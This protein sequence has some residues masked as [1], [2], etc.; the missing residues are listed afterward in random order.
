MEPSTEAGAAATAVTAGR[1][2]SWPP[3]GYID[4][5]GAAKRLGVNPRTLREWVTDGTLAY[6]G[7]MAVAPDGRR[8]R[9]YEVAALDEARARMRAAVAGRATLP[10]G[11]VSRDDA[12]AMLGVVPDTLALWHTNGRL[13]CGTWVKTAD[14]KRRKVYPAVE[15]ERLRAALATAIVSRVTPP[16]GFVDIDGALAMFGVTRAAWNIWKRQGKVPRGTKWRSATATYCRIYA[17]EE[18]R[19]VFDRLR[20]PDQVFR[21]PGGTGRYHIPEGF[22]QLREACAMFGVEDKTFLRWESEGL[23]TCGRKETGRRIKIYQRAELQRLLDENGR[24]A[25]PYP[26]PHLSG[27]YRVPLAGHDMERREA[28]IDVA[29]LPLVEGRRWHCS[30]PSEDGAGRVATF[31]QSGESRLHHLIVGAHMGMSLGT[32]ECVAHRNRD[33]LDCRRE[34]LVVRTRSESNGNHRKVRSFCGRPPTSR[35]K[36][37]CWD[38]AA[39]KWIASIKKD[40]VSRHLG[41]YHDELAAAEAYDEAARELF[42]EHARLNFPDGIDAW[43]ARDEQCRIEAEANRAERAEAA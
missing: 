27:V 15:V 14:G 43:L 30:G 6:G 18:L 26:D 16:E 35:F 2:T 39:E 41:R 20:G 38:K 21:V 29:D 24:Y 40:H 3:A 25:P 34:N 4:Q 1:A 22:V 8:W 11:Y 33:P 9:I 17:I 31:N 19:E 37:V 23:I 28:I 36:G 7:T 32:N 13:R 10:Q 5:A 12:A 42:G